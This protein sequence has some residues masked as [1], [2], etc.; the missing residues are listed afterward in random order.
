MFA[1]LN[2]AYWT[3]HL[4]HPSS[5]LCFIY[6]YS[7]ITPTLTV[8]YTSLKNCCL[9]QQQL[10]LL[11][12][13]PCFCHPTYFLLY[14]VCIFYQPICMHDYGSNCHVKIV[15]AKTTQVSGG[16]E[17]SLHNQLLSNMTTRLS[18]CGLSPGRPYLF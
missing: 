14:V 9:L 18:D 6:L 10:P 12:C 11:G 13:G 7:L 15:S 5:V 3:S 16:V 1:S 17:Y 2:V 4:P 8:T